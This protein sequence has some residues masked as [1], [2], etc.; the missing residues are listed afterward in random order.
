MKMFRAM[1]IL[2]STACLA[3]LVACSSGTPA[4]N[5]PPGESPAEQGATTDQKP[6]EQPAQ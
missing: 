5:T 1:G 3:A 4:N 2:L 6:I